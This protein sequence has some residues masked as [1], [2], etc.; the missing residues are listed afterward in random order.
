MSPILSRLI[1]SVGGGAVGGIR[2]KQD[3]SN[4]VAGNV[5]WYFDGADY[6]FCPSSSTLALGSGDFTI[7]MWIKPDD[8]NQRTWIGWVNDSPMFEYDSGYRWYSANIGGIDLK[9]GTISTGVWQHIAVSRTSTTI[10]IYKNGTRVAT[11][12]DDRNFTNNTPVLGARNSG[13]GSGTVHFKGYISNLRLIKGTSIY[14]G[15]TIIVPTSPLTAVS[16]TQLL[17]FQDT[18]LIDKSANNHTLSNTGSTF[19]SDGPF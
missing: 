13:F 11:G 12:I 8:T 6:V 5:S 18:T 16:N 7:E 15:T 17:T 9:G 2:R 14:N 19:S 1:S 3:S 4:S 10:Q